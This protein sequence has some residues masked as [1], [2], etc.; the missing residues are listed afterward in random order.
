MK[1]Q[2]LFTK[3]SDDV[4]S[5][6]KNKSSTVKIICKEGWGNAPKKLKNRTREQID[7]LTQAFLPRKKFDIAALEKAYKG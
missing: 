3:H 7:R 1:L 5:K 4:M 2:A 6:S